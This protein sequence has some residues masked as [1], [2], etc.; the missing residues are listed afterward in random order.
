MA[1]IRRFI[2]MLQFMTTL[3]VKVNVQAGR[4]DFGKGLAMAPL[5]GLVIGVLVAGFNYLFAMLIP[6][7]VAAVL[8]MAAYILLTGGL[9][10]DG[11]GDTADG[12]FSNRP[13]ERILEIMKDSRVGTNAV[14]AL[15]LVMLADISLI[16]SFEKSEITLVL[17][18]MPVAGRIGSLVGAGTSRYAG[19]SDS[20][21]RWSVEY[22]GRREII[23]GLVLYIVIIVAA[24]GIFTWATISPE[25]FTEVSRTV[26]DSSL[27]VVDLLRK[28]TGLLRT[29]AGL[30]PIYALF[31]ATV[32]IPPLSSFILARLLG[33]K[34]GGVT[35]DILGAI[36]EINQ[37]IFLFTAYLL[38]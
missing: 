1:Y 30:P 6:P 21:G 7:L 10:M 38:A 36:C 22:C 8:T 20:P 4:Q 12:I 34:L 28:P 14:I 32:V 2:L 16:A 3:P 25:R 23:I 31:P 15:V 33:K 9:H 35:G 17:L 11:L 29:A 13:A 26:A 18:L 24:A 19:K 37:V 27:A 5:V